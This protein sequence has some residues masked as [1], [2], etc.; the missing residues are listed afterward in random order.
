MCRSTYDP[1]VKPDDVVRALAI[2]VACEEPQVAERI[3]AQLP[4]FL[5]LL[6][7]VRASDGAMQLARSLDTLRRAQAATAAP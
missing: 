7:A 5:D 4:P 3:A 2:L 6:D 1:R